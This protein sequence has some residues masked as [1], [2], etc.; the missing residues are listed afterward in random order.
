M[1]ILFADLI[2]NAYN[3]ELTA[4]VRVNS[5]SV[6]NVVAVDIVSECVLRSIKISATD[7]FFYNADGFNLAI[8]S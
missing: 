1:H 3:S 5:F 6:G 2:R 7:F 4:N 8:L